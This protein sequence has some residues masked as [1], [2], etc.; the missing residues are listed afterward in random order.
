M[1]LLLKLN[2][3]WGPNISVLCQGLTAFLKHETYNVRTDSF[4]ELVTL[5]SLALLGPHPWEMG[6]IPLCR[7][8]VLGTVSR[9]VTIPSPLLCLGFTLAPLIP[10]PKILYNVLLSWLFQFLESSW[11][12]IKSLS[13]KS[14]KGSKT[15][16][17]VV[18]CFLFF[19]PT[20]SQFIQN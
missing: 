2:L 8:E 1:A 3:S 15:A 14:F 11:S 10:T 16:Y 20:Y 9:S 19:L 4:K 12:F 17:P 6:H 13:T 18:F 7:S 5:A